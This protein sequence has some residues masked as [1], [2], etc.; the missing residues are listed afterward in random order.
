MPA[1][2]MNKLECFAR[3]DEVKYCHLRTRELI[4]N[5]EST[6][7]QPLKNLRQLRR[8]SRKAEFG[9]VVALYQFEQEMEER[10]CDDDKEIY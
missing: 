2:Q 6:A 9:L 8:E 1:N 5:A 7:I 4:A 10:A 3:F